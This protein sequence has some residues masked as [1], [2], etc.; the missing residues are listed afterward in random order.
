MKKYRIFFK[1]DRRGDEPMTYVVVYYGFF[2]KMLLWDHWIGHMVYGFIID[3]HLTGEIPTKFGDKYQ[4]Q[5]DT[6]RVIETEEEYQKFKESL[7]ITKDNAFV[8]FTSDKHE[9]DKRQTS[10]PQNV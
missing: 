4:S 2:R 6:E 3:G 5:Y 9:H 7:G 8:F 10:V 1:Y